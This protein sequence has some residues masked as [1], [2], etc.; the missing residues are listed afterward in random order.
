[1]ISLI[2]EFKFLDRGFRDTLVLI[3]GWATDYRIFSSLRLNFNYIVPVKL[4]PFDC[5]RQLR[6]FLNRQSIS[7]ISLLGWSLGGFLAA[8]FALKRPQMVDEVILLG[9][10]KRYE[11]AALKEVRRRL[12]K[13]RRG[14]L[15][16]FYRECFSPNDK[17]GLNW[18]RKNLLKDYL[19]TMMTED[20][21]SGLNYLTKACI[22]KDFLVCIKKIRIFHGCEDKIAPFK[23]AQEL[24]EGLKQV[25]LVPISGAGHIPFLSRGFEESFNNE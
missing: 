20:L 9:I 22:D 15:F 3:P 1:M 14:Y 5:S 25:E 13:N 12:T 18:F 24:A 21:L 11:S 17:K 10:R 2:S 8:E 16:K 19:D 7:K 4:S 23:E 6:E